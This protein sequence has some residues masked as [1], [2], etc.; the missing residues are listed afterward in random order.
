MTAS[1]KIEVEVYLLDPAVSEEPVDSLECGSS[2]TLTL[3]S[4]K[5]HLIRVQNTGIDGVVTVELC[6]SSGS[7][8]TYF[9]DRCVCIVIIFCLLHYL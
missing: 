9:Y 1:Q 4:N 5:N 8:N 3:S 6:P 2:K 7:E